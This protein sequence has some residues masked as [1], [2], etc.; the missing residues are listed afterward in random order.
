MLGYKTVKLI[1]ELVQD[2]VCL[3][4]AFLSSRGWDDDEIET[5]AIYR[6]LKERIIH[7]EEN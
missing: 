1:H 6:N 7:P 4:P 2:E 5:I 3:Y